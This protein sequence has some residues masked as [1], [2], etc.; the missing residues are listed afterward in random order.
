MDSSA[1][2][3]LVLVINTVLSAIENFG[4]DFFTVK[5]TVYVIGFI[6]GGVPAILNIIEFFGTKQ[7]KKRILFSSVQRLMYGDSY[8]K[9]IF[10]QWVEGSSVF[11]N[12]LCSGKPVTSNGFLVICKESDLKSLEFNGSNSDVRDDWNVREVDFGY[13]SK[14]EMSNENYSLSKKNYR[15]E[16]IYFRKGIY[17]YE[18]TLVLKGCIE[19]ESVFFENDIFRR[20]IGNKLKKI[21]DW[22]NF[23][24]DYIMYPRHVLKTEN[25][26]DIRIESIF[27]PSYNEIHFVYKTKDFPE[28]YETPKIKNCD[29]NMFKKS[30]LLIDHLDEKMWI[31]W[32]LR[33]EK[34]DSMILH[35][36]TLNQCMEKL[37]SKE[38]KM[39]EISHLIG[40]KSVYIE[41]S[42]FDLKNRIMGEAIRRLSLRAVEDGLLFKT[43][44]ENYSSAIVSYL[45]KIE[46]NFSPSVFTKLTDYTLDN[47][48]GYRID[49]GLTNWKRKKFLSDISNIKSCFGL[50]MTRGIDHLPPS[51]SAMEVISLHLNKNEIDK[52]YKCSIN[53]LKETLEK[54]SEERAEKLSSKIKKIE[55]LKSMGFKSK[56]GSLENILEEV[57][58]LPNG[59]SYKDKLKC[60]EKI[61]DSFTKEMNRNLPPQILK[62]LKSEYKGK[63]KV[64]SL[65]SENKAGSKNDSVLFPRRGGGGEEGMLEVKGKKKGKNEKTA[66][67]K[68]IF[69][70]VEEAKNSR[71]NPYLC[72]TKFVKVWCLRSK[73]SILNDHRYESGEMKLM[74][75]MKSKISISKDPTERAEIS[76]TI[77]QLRVNERTRKSLR[78]GNWLNLTVV[79]LNVGVLVDCFGESNLDR[80]LSD[81]MVKSKE[82]I[83]KKIG[84]FKERSRPDEIHQLSRGNPV[85]IEIFNRF[86]PLFDEDGSKLDL[87]CDVVCDKIANQFAF[88]L[89]KK[90]INKKRAQPIKVIRKRDGSNE[91]KVDKLEIPSKKIYKISGQ[92]RGLLNRFYQEDDL[93]GTTTI[94]D[95]TDEE[96][97]KKIMR[98]RIRINALR[99]VERNKERMAKEKAESRSM[100][101]KMKE[102]EERRLKN[103]KIEDE[104]EL[105]L[106]IFD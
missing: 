34:Q 70:T 21:G 83:L 33:V 71:I 98:E 63:I 6:I 49:L 78:E 101:K 46:K 47:I 11:C 64:K 42:K 93:I 97:E 43:G 15:T 79:N 103:I 84:K 38:Y 102:E 23:E 2:I 39:F 25:L 105:S 104:E 76:F 74:L 53:P 29:I 4:Y 26:G 41:E 1:L 20:E 77:S 37:K 99:N 36:M 94:T 30:I 56:D 85:P 92:V 22:S 95:L 12:I 32:D 58:N 45:K 60:T 18:S 50:E 51:R 100:N 10:R 68:H 87:F 82:V 73:A 72:F 35:S 88:V 66:N 91:I 54:K 5:V 80:K 61:R 40:N 27:N 48:K 86:N 17:D 106:N 81:K 16:K 3:S 55:K 7:S 13:S 44:N 96:A 9:V 59:C 19:G 14:W 65:N 62:V 28:G 67:I 90:K 57:K 8:N 75:S 69:D 31:E 89:P 52:N 24:Y